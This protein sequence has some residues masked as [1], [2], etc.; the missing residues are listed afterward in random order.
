VLLAGEAEHAELRDAIGLLRE[1]SF[2]TEAGRADQAVA[3]LEHRPQPEVIVLAQSRPG[4]VP[5]RTLERLRRLAPL[6]GIVS[7]LGSW[8]E[9]QARAWRPTAGEH[10]LY[11]YEFP[12]WWARQL[13]YCRA[14]RCPDW[15]R[16]EG[17]RSQ[18]PGARQK[19]GLTSEPTPRNSRG[20]IAISTSQMEVFAALADVLLQQG[21]AS[22][23]QSPGKPVTLHGATAGVWEGGQL[24]DCEADR[25]AAFCRQLVCDGAPVVTL[26][27]FPRRDR[28]QRAREAGAVAV[29]GKPWLSADLV[30]TLEQLVRRHETGDLAAAPARAA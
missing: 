2:L 8:C 18:E 19:G 4:V 23:W 7:L 20:L 15:A 9:G 3:A 13:A 10:R 6:A 17:A 27:D 29:L 1:T 11:W 25:L 14:G 28:C 16:M 24:D 12:S 30:Y 5:P 22:A 21:F 26:L